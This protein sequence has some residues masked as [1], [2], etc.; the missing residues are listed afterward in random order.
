MLQGNYI[1]KSSKKF[2]KAMIIVAYET[3][4]DYIS[5][6]DF[7]GVKKPLKDQAQMFLKN[8]FINT[9]TFYYNIGQSMFIIKGGQVNKEK[10][11]FQIT[12]H[13]PV[14]GAAY[15]LYS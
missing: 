13:I 1:E 2:I 10:R 12:E 7:L 9:W 15:F 3:D 6:A 11:I 5:F 8:P 14:P 4:V